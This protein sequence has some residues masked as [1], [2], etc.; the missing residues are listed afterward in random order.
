MEMWRSAYVMAYM[1]FL[2]Q[3]ESKLFLISYCVVIYT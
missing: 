3:R 2:T 1:L